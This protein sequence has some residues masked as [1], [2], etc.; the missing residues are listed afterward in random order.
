MKEKN[1]AANPAWIRAVSVGIAERGISKTELFEKSGCPS[2]VYGSAVINGRS[3]SPDYSEKISKFLGI[4][5]P[6]TV[7]IPEAQIS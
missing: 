6:Y 4:T 5:V 1:V 7:K 3:L 2:R